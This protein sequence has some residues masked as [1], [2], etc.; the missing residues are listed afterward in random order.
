MKNE[1]MTPMQKDK[2][3]T[4]PMHPEVLSDQ[5]GICPKCG[6]ELVEKGNQKANQVRPIRIDIQLKRGAAIH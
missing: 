5:P 4:C 6:M 1:M 3:Y 2:K